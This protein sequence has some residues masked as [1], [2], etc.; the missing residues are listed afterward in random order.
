MVLTN[1]NMKTLDTE[2]YE[3]RQLWLSEFGLDQGDVMTDDEGTE[4][5]L[6]PIE[7]DEREEYSKLELPPKLQTHYQEPIPF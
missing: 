7:D 4:Y 3:K 2:T 5:I 6:R 1:I